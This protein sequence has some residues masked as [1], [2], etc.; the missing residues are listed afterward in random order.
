M[1]KILYTLLTILLLLGQSNVLQANPL[2]DL[3]KYQRRIFKKIAPSVVYIANNEG[4]G[5]GFFVDN[6]GLIL[7]NSH[8]VGTQ[9]TVTVV[10]QSGK[11]YKGKVVQRAT[12]AIDLALVRIAAK[13]TPPLTI[14]RAKAKIGN[15]VASVGH[16]EGAIWSY[17]TGMVSNSY[18]T[19]KGDQ[20]LQT[21]IP[22]N[23]GNS[24]GPIVDTKGDVVGI[25]TAG[26]TKANAINFAIPSQVILRVMPKIGKACDCV[27]IHAP[28]GVPIFVDGKN[29]GVGPMVSVPGQKGRTMKIHAV[30]RGKMVRR[31]ARYP[32]TKT[33]RLE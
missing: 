31:K 3:Q 14:S 12:Q 11:T 20:V 22:L 15:W 13:G 1:M 19:K 17:S 30:I 2:V 18:V 10:T 9:N 24:G 8:V 25:A 6:N 26:I 27:V 4:H 23:P 32:K 28:K 5:S 7:T 21:Q 16:G 33:V 29:V